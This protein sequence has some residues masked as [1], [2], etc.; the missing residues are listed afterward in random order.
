MHLRYPLPD[1]LRGE[2]G[3]PTKSGKTYKSLEH[4]R[5]VASYLNRFGVQRFRYQ[6]R[7]AEREDGL[8]ELWRFPAD[9]GAA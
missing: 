3:E 7:I 4:I 9:G 8:F 6:W 1:Q 5:A 2:G